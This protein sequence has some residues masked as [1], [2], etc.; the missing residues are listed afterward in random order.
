M[1]AGSAIGLGD[2]GLFGLARSCARL[3]QK[4]TKTLT[5]QLWFEVPGRRGFVNITPTV[6]ALVQRSGVQVLVKI[7]GE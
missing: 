6:A 4:V 5:E 1:C 2:R 7:I 3:D